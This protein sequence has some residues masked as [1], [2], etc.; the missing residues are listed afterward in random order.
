MTEVDRI[1]AL[2]EELQR[3]RE[4]EVRELKVEI[5]EGKLEIAR[6]RRGLYGENGIY[7]GLTGEFQKLRDEELTALK[8][9]VEK[10]DDSVDDLN[11][12]DKQR[13][14]RDAAWS[15]WAYVL[16][17]VILGSA[18]MAMVTLVTLMLQTYAFQ[19]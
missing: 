17:P 6:L 19:G 15:R 12:S 2:R 7:R 18:L 4:V 8:E 16:V 11:N 9:R 14:K 10:I 1:S 13:T 3:L 5:A